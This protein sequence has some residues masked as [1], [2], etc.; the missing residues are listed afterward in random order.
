MKRE[1]KRDRIMRQ[2]NAL[3]AVRNGAVSFGRTRVGF[4]V[5]FGV[6]SFSVVFGGSAIAGPTL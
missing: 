6:A 2:E 4:W 5:Y 3:Q 1:A